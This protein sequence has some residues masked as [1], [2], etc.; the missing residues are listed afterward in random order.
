[1][2]NGK[3]SSW[4]LGNIIAIVILGVLV[5]L[6]GHFLGVYD[7]NRQSKNVAGAENTFQPV[8][9]KTLSYDGVNGKSALDLL[10]ADHKVETQDSSFGVFVSSI[11][12]TANSENKFW[13][14]YIDGKL[15][16]ISSDQYTT[17][18]GEKIE[19]RYEAY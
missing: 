6:G 8:V 15:S 14:F 1:M 4:G 3:S 5:I 10:K 12:G 2:S 17:K 19:W 9:E 16:T 18:D 7:S 13:M 11:D